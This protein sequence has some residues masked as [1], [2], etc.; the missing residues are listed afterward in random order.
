MASPQ[1][2]A[3]SAYADEWSQQLFDDFR[4]VGVVQDML[5]HDNSGGV[6]R[7]LQGMLALAFKQSFLLAITLTH[8]ERA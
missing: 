2:D 8:Q 1:L 4:G 7:I 5:A 6:T 3:V